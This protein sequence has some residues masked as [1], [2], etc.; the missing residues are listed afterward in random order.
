[1]RPEFFHFVL[2][3]Q[4]SPLQGRY[5]ERIGGRMHHHFIDPAFDIAV[6][7]LEFL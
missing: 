1:L 5:L 7:A 4:L 3:G 6:F 2:Q